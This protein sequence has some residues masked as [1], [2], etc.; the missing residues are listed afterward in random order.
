[1][2]S[3]KQGFSETVLLIL[4]VKAK[5]EIEQQLFV[6]LQNDYKSRNKS[7]IWGITTTGSTQVAWEF[8]NA[9]TTLR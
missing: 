5:F 4:Q 1:M 8:I 3:W 6:S 2:W 7:P 9:A